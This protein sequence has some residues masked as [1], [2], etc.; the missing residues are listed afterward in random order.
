MHQITAIAA[1]NRE[2]L[3][4]GQAAARETLLGLAETASST[5]SPDGSAVTHESARRLVDQSI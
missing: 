2:L 4:S 3:T 1:A 5:Y